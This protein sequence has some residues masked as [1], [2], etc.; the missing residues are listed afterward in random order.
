MEL[1]L[2]NTA[3]PP[4]FTGW[5]IVALASFVKCWSYGLAFGVLGISV[6]A[7][8]ERFDTTRVIA[9]LPLSLISAAIMLLAPVLGALYGRISIRRSIMLGAVLGA[10][11]HL[12]LASIHD[13]RV[14]LAC[15]AFLVGPGVALTGGMPTSVLASY[16]FVK[17]KGVALGIV[18]LP[19]GLMIVPLVAV[20]VL[21]SGGLPTLYLATGLAFLLIIPAAFYLVDRPELVNQTPLGNSDVAMSEADS[22]TTPTIS[23]QSV[24]TRFDFWALVVTIGIIVGGSSMKYA[25]LIPLLNEQNRSIEQATL[26]LSIAGGCG[27]VGALLF[28][29]LADRFGGARI[30]IGTAIVQAVMW[31]IFLLPVSFLLL[32]IDAAII[33]MCGG[34]IAAAQGVFIC[35][36]F[37][38]QNFSRVLGLLAISLFPFITGINPLA[39]YLRDA[40]GDYRTAI[41]SLIAASIFV[42]TILTSVTYRKPKLPHN[43]IAA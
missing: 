10:A 21:Q 16:W 24:L 43:K 42:A 4:H 15:Y 19:L 17:H 38:Q 41:I 32:T 1:L 12:C 14:M 29:W 3:F 30:I 18:N 5:R 35:Q 8:Q 33:G 9:S 26:L 37:G 39:G 2:Q 27:A 31:F 11:G 22:T 7:I 28:G 13:W 36:R 6:L 23:L 20:E 25:H 34:G 40:T